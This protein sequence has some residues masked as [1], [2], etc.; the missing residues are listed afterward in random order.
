MIQLPF[1]PV[2]GDPLPLIPDPPSGDYFQY[3]EFLID[4]A[5]DEGKKNSKNPVNE[6]SSYLQFD[7]NSQPAINRFKQL[8]SGI[9]D[10]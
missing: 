3:D 7:E 10:L 1:Y 9:L 5:I 4:E 8:T 6:Q 2:T